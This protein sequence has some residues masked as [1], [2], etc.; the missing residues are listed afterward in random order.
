MENDCGISLAVGKQRIDID[1]TG[2]HIMVYCA[3]RRNPVFERLT[4]LTTLFSQDRKNRIAKC[5]KGSQKVL[6]AAAGLCM[7]EGLRDAG[8]D[9]AAMRYGADA[10]G[11]PFICDHP[12]IAF[13]ISHSGD[14]AAAVFVRPGTESDCAESVHTI[15]SAGIDIERIGRMNERIARILRETDGDLETKEEL[16]RIWT[17]REAF[18]KCTGIGLAGIRDDFHFEKS[19]NGDPV[20]R[21]E[22]F[23]GDF[24]VIEPEAPEGYC[25]TVVVRKY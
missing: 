21:Q 17:A 8:I 11:K 6:S 22:L 4:E 23:E 3:D 18:V 2:H 9:E 15:Y 7:L 24:T 14:Y 16:C 25:I 20:L 10:H 12:E 13:N 19:E 5:G 1:G